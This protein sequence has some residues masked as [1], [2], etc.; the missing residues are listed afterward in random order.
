MKPLLILLLGL[1]FTA[2][3]HAQKDTIRIGTYN[4]LNYGNSANRPAYKNQRLQPILQPINPDIACF[5]E[6]STVLPA[7]LDTLVTEKFLPADS[8]SK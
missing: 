2:N 3:L 7:M 4:L 5:N 8:K 6:V 1:I